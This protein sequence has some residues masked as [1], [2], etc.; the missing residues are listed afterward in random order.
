MKKLIYI[1][2]LL[3]LSG[4][5]HFLKEYSQDLVVAK[6]VSDLDEILLGS[7]YIPS[8]Q[9]SEINVTG[10]YCPWLNLLDDN[11]NTVIGT[12]SAI[13]FDPSYNAFGYTTWQLEVGRDI[14]GRNLLPDDFTWNN[15]YYRIN[16][17]NIILKEAGDMKVN[18]EADVQALERIKG[19][20][21]FLRAQFYLILVNLYANAYVPEKATGTLGVP[22]KLTAY[23]E[24]DKDKEVQFD[25]SPLTTVYTQ[26]ISDLKEAAG[27]LTRSPQTKPLHRAS[28]EAALLLL[29][30][31]YL[32]MQDWTNARDVA[33]E[34]LETNNQLQDMASLKEGE[35]FLQEKSSEVIFSQGGLSVHTAVSGE[36]GVFCVTND[37]YRLYD[38]TNDYRAAG[39]FS[40]E[41][42]SDSLALTGKY[43]LGT[44]RSHISDCF[45][46]RNAEGYLNMAEACA[47]LGD[48]KA[49]EWLNGLRRNRIKNYTD[50][51]YSGEELIRQ[52]RD[53]RRKELC[54]EGHRWFDLR[55]YAVS[56]KTPFKKEIR[57]LF[58][59]YNQEIRN[60]FDYAEIFILKKDD[61]AY[62]FRIPLSVLDRDKGM[63]DNPREVRE[64]ADVIRDVK[65]VEP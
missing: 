27:C 18:S 20:C 2:C 12:G 11:I 52:I 50:Q 17:T 25:R 21:Y 56:V 33:G 53:E 54:F 4:C 6:N 61:P 29:S 3:I 48:N 32:Y 5:N 42:W 9:Y 38:E 44:Y 37:L 47:M 49:N 23:V 41:Y 7:A 46:L 45:M 14:Q 64:V 28:K 13:T 8:I 34:F 30:R 15:L 62:T 26:I 19:E 59:H 55:R 57:R 22:L 1:S 60:E 63:P 51:N 65:T 39:W 10:D 43:K 24:H 58:A 31:V 35:A 36:K 16:V 40:H